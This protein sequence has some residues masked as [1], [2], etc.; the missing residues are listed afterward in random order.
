MG[1]LENQWRTWESTAYPNAQFPPGSEEGEVAGVDLAL[2]V[3]DVAKILRDFFV[4]GRLDEV[5]RAMLP[6]VVDGLERAVPL[7]A[8]PGRAYFD[9]ALSLL[10]AIDGAT[11]AGS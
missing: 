7:L 1:D 3:G 8:E 5:D 4:D 11:R 2:V 9:L 10:R 6:P